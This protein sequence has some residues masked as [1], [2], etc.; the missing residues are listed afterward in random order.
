MNQKFV[1]MLAVVVVAMTVIAFVMSGDDSTSMDTAKLFPDINLMAVSKVEVVSADA[2]VTIHLVD[3]QWRVAEKSNYQAERKKLSQLVSGIGN[4]ELSERKTT[5]PEN[6]ARLG[7]A[8]LESTDL[9]SADLESADLES[10]DPEN[11]LGNTLENILENTLENKGSEVTKLTLT[12]QDSAFSVLIGDES[13]ARKGT[14]VREP[15]ENQVWLTSQSLNVEKLAEDW[16]D[17]II[18]DVEAE[19]ISSVVMQSGEGRLAFLRG[20]DGEF[21]LQDLPEGRSLKYPS[22]VGEPARALV[23]V[24][25]EDVELHDAGR[26]QGASVATFGLKNS[27]EIV[28][29]A[30]QLDEDNWVHFSVNRDE[31]DIREY[32]DIGLWDYLVVSYVFDDFVKTLDDVLAEPE[33]EEDAA[34]DQGNPKSE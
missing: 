3:G 27:T 5:K 31:N 28:V 14:F 13:S 24:R 19:D 4:T 29:Q 6:F 30:I 20:E 10:T 7:V 11:T 1:L 18:I 32:G 34:A 12:S 15:G 22:I 21:T 2:A 23:K 9:E 33:P 8:D 26:W 16:L 17:P 25:L